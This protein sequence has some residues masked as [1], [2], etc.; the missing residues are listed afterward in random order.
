MEAR[1]IRAVYAGCVYTFKSI[2]E[3]ASMKEEFAQEG[4]WLQLI[5]EEPEGEED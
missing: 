2:E 5:N 1:E 4:K 3:Y